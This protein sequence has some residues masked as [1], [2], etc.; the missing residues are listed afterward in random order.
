MQWD[1]AGSSLGDS[2]KG[3]GS[4]L[5][6][7]REI[8]GKKTGGLVARMS[9][10]TGLYGTN[11]SPRSVGEPPVP[12]FFGYDWILALVLKPIDRTLAGLSPNLPKK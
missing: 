12:G 2:L 3:S 7:R 1:L 4:S 11:K 5:G 10:A 8:A 9:E 6:T